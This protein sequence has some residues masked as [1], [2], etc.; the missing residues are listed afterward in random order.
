MCRVTGKRA[1]RPRHADI[2]RAGTGGRAQ[3]LD[4]AAELFSEQGY[5]AATTRQ[6]ADAV[7]VRQ[8]SIY[9]H[10]SNKQEILAELL[11]GTVRPSLEYSRW[12]TPTGEPAL[13]QLYALTRFDVTLLSG[14]QWNIGA[15]YTMPELRA[16]EFAPFREERALLRRAYGD[17]VAAAAAEGAITVEDESVATSLAFALAESVIAMRAEGS[18][19][20]PDLPDLIAAGVLRILGCP[21]R[22]IAKVR[23]RAVEALVRAPGDESSSAVS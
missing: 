16:A 3:I 5:G 13:V 17:R 20:H 11:A 2:G 9:Y 1:G 15:L 8:A 12:L 23:S 7:G 10:F 14:G 18:P 21:E 4:A 19:S 6:I 22:S